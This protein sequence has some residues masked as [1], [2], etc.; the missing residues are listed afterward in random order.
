[1]FNRSRFRLLFLAQPLPSMSAFRALRHRD[2]SIYF[3]GQLISLVG[4]WMQS[5]A[6]GWWVYRLTGRVSLLGLVMFAAQAPT[7]LLAP[8]G[9]MLAD[10]MPAR[11]LLLITQATYLVQAL[12]MTLLAFSGH[13][14]I[15]MILGLAVASGAITAFDLPGR[16]VLVAQVVDQETLPN[17]IALQSAIFH[18]SRIVGP[19]FAL[20]IVAI[21][22][23]GWCFL[24]N[25]V[26]YMASIAAL[27]VLRTRYQ[28]EYKE[29]HSALQQITE[30][31]QFIWERPAFRHLMGLLAL[32]VGLGMPFTTL[33][34]ALAQGVLHIDAR[35]LGWLVVSSGLGATA[36]AMLLATRK[37]VK[38][39][40]RM[41]FASAVFFAASLGCFAQARSLTPAMILLPLASF[42]LVAF[43]TA[44]NTLAQLMTP[45]AMRGRVTSLYSMVFMF[46]MPL[47]I[48]GTG[49]LGQRL[50]LPL[51]LGLGAGGCL[52]GALVFAG[53]Y[54][55]RTVAP[56]DTV[57]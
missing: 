46:A 4:T 45:N 32:I 36:G 43:N 31:F 3:A 9:G 7:L 37:E 8:L 2:F 10:R 48:L 23:E 27:A 38:G 54:P 40:D 41:V 14:T 35:G 25:A 16:Q 52:V 13:P 39:L 47:G 51:T 19:F 24:V 49:F 53:V 42:G 12:G 18:G 55:K 50:G 17:A 29:R 15:P 30:G 20:H 57:A 26:S 33:L 6:L 44:T 1:M 5:V 34:P 56:V 21:S 22:H 11:T 28:P